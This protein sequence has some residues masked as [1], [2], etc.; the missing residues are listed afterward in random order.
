MELLLEKVAAGIADF[1]E[2]KEIGGWKER[3]DV[4]LTHLD[5]ASVDKRDEQL[6]C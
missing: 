1:G 5:G 3:L 4:V 2:V 6:H